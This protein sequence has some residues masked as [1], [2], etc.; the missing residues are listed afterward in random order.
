MP[1]AEQRRIECSEWAE[2]DPSA[3]EMPSLATVVSVPAVSSRSCSHMVAEPPT[4]SRL[5]IDALRANAR[6]ALSGVAPAQV[7]LGDVQVLVPDA[8]PPR[9]P[10]SVV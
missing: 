1:L 9:R 7:K 2:N 10:A 4:A 6:A 3:R 8:R 5:L